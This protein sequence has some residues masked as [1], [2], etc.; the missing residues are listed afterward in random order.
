MGDDVLTV[1]CIPSLVSVDF[2]YVSGHS[3]EWALIKISVADVLISSVGYS[4]FLY[5][6]ENRVEERASFH[7]CVVLWILS[8]DG[9]S[10]KVK[11]IRNFIDDL[12][13][14]CRMFCKRDVLVF[15][16][17]VTWLG[18]VLRFKFVVGGIWIQLARRFVLSRIGMLGFILSSL[19]P[20]QVFFQKVF[21]MLLWLAD[22]EA[23]K[24]VGL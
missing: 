7:F 8:G 6:G 12:F 2:V 1:I 19:L 10:F 3:V 21:F 9:R 18:V 24:S 11:V 23:S 22:L 16:R 20:S 14:P 15:F 13:L 17:P 4:V 5:C